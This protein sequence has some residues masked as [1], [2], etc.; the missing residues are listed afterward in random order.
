[1]TFPKVTQTT[2]AMI[3]FGTFLVSVLSFFT[4]FS[5]MLI[6]LSWP[7]ALL[8]SLGL[9]VALLG[10]A[11]N[12]MKVKSNRLTYVTVFLVAASFSVF[13]SYANFNFSLKE[14]TRGHKVRGEYAD[15]ARPIVRQYSAVAK[16]TQFKGTY[17]VKR[18]NQLI[19]MEKKNGWSTVVDEGSQD[20]FV[21][22]VID[23]ARRTVTSWQQKQGADY[24]QG[25]GEGIIVNYLNTWQQQLGQS[26]TA[27]NEYLTFTDSAVLALSG[28]TS[29]E[30]QHDLVNQVAMRLPVGEIRQITGQSPTNLPEPPSMAA[31]IE[32]PMNSQEALMLVIGDL[33]E[34]DR[35]TFFSLMFAIAVDLIVIVMAFA[36]SRTTDEIDYLFTRVQKDSYRRTRKMLLG[37]PYEMSRSLDKNLER[38]QIASRY[39][40]A[41]SKALRDFEE[42]KKSI[43]LHRGP[44][45]AVSATDSSP[46]ESPVNKW[47]KLDATR[48]RLKKTVLT[49]D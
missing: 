19:A 16:E 5:G 38:M 22:S 44:E 47:V 24:H 11:W 40:L 27:V 34:M 2:T 35:L 4:T 46:L 31:Y 29:V 13:F 6:L 49:R 26:M 41:L 42:S 23:G 25:A 1:M 7:L 12:L 48:S 21:Q 9:Q 30:E 33:Q 39:G 17:Q 18:L 43:T 3:Y 14:N 10:L 45:S 37:D 28:T 32:K 36:G 20:A 8:G 15:V